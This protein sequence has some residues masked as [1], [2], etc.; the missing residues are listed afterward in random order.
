M[1]ANPQCTCQIAGCPLVDLQKEGA[2]SPT[3]I[4]MAAWFRERTVGEE[5]NGRVLKTP[6]HDTW[7]PT[8]GEVLASGLA[9]QG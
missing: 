5:F 9:T 3:D 4:K 7:E 6:F 2:V 1:I 8:H